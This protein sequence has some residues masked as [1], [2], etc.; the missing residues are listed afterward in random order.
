[1]FNFIVVGP[2]P[3]EVELSRAFVE[4]KKDVLPKDYRGIDFSRLNIFMI[5]G[6]KNTLNSMSNTAQ[7][8]SRKYLEKWV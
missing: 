7:L 4:I 8:A 5:E 2:G 3:T 1:L 6:T